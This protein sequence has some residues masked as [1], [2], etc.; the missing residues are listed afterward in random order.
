M[1]I[2]F[3]RQSKPRIAH[4]TDTRVRKFHA[5]RQRGKAA[6]MEVGGVSNSAK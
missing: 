2:A 3:R 4:A 5:E 1:G 6:E